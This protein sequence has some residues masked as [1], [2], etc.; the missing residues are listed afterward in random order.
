MILCSIFFSAVALCVWFPF[1]STRMFTFVFFYLILQ[2]YWRN[3]RNTQTKMET[4]RSFSFI[5]LMMMTN[6]HITND[7][8]FFSWLFVCFVCSIWYR[9]DFPPKQKNLIFFFLKKKWQFSNENLKFVFFSFLW[10]VIFNNVVT[11]VVV[12][13]QNY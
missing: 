10:P 8:W 7:D 12:V 1:I 2:T 9:S 11:V 3:Q 13:K 4:F 5:H 6:K